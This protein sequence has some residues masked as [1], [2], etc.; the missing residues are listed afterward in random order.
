MLSLYIKNSIPSQ[1]LNVK[2]KTITFL[3]NNMRIS[4]WI[5]VRKRILN[6]T[7]NEI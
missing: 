7:K 5:S 3:E 1:I 2:I 6:D 4:S